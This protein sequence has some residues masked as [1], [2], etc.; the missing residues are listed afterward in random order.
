MLPLFMLLDVS[1][2]IASQ[3]VKLGAAFT[4]VLTV[5]AAAWGIS[6]IAKTA[7]EGISRQPEASNDLRGAM[8]ISSAL[9]EGVAF[10]AIVVSLLVLF[11]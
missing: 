1:L 9:I 11:V 8:I 7:L 3:W 4:A 6:K 2:E 5:G 10:F